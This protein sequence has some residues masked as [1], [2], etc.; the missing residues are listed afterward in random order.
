[1]LK[2]EKSVRFLMNVLT[3]KPPL[4]GQ[5]SMV[6]SLIIV[7]IIVAVVIVI[8]IILIRSCYVA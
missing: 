4:K 7:I 2:V 8:I 6:D 1:M 5:V 3:P